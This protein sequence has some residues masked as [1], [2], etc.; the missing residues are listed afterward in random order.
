MKLLILFQLL[1]LG[2]VLYL[3][4]RN[5]MMKK[6]QDALIQGLE[7]VRY[8]R[9][10][11]ARE[12]FF[13]SWLR[14]MPFEAKGV[15]IDDGGSLRL[16]GFWLKGSKAFDVA[17]DKSQCQ[18]EWLGNRTLKAGNLYWAK[19]TTARWTLFFCADTGMY[20]LPSR[21]ALSDIF[22]SVFPRYPLAGEQT[23][24]FALDK[25]P[26]SLALVV[27]FLLALVFALVDTFV[28]SR[29]EL[30]DSQLAAIWRNP[31]MLIG[32]LLAVG[33]C[34]IGF[35]RWLTGGR[36]PARESL[37]LSVFTALTLFAAAMPAAKRVDQWL[38]TEPTRAYAYQITTPGY[39]DPV[40]QSL[41]LPALKFPRMKEFWQQYPEGA[42]YDVPFLRGPMGLWQLDHQ[43]FDPPI[44]DFYKSRP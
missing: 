19:L 1:G 39:L 29:Y 26:R 37:V 5:R 27:L 4:W 22:R 24:D 23:Q 43:V 2:L 42:R 44:L 12:P 6:R 11:M 7:G 30:T 36:V 35:Y 13:K 28:I 14:L 41:G 21:E 3:Y 16:R 34:C 32:A 17:I 15:L 31:L 8:W 33:G 9:I 10:N 40:D 20:A 25:N 18:V 38:A